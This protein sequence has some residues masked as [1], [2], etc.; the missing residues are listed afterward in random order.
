MRSAFDIFITNALI[1]ISLACLIIMA[2]VISSKYRTK[3]RLEKRKKAKRRRFQNE[4][5][6]YGSESVR[7][8]PSYSEDGKRIKIVKKNKPQ[9]R[10][11]LTKRV[12]KKG[13]RRR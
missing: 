9:K 7:P 2:L 11:P 13:K 1:F 12:Y 5:R 4:I 3:K 8:R 6:A 10:R